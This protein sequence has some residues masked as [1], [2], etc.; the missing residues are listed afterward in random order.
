[1][2]KSHWMVGIT[3]RFSFKKYCLCESYRISKT[4]A[5]VAQWTECQPENQG[6]TGLILS[7]GTA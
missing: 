7:Q 4:L 5:G 6:V 1:M 2:I 3:E